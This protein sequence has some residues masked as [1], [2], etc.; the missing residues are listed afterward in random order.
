MLTWMDGTGYGEGGGRCWCWWTWWWLAGVICWCILTCLR[1]CTLR[2]SSTAKGCD[3]PQHLKEVFEAGSAT[4]IVFRFSRRFICLN[5]DSVA[6]LLKRAMSTWTSVGSHFEG[7]FSPLTR[8][9]QLSRNGCS[10]FLAGWVQQR[11]GASPGD[12]QFP[13]RMERYPQG[14]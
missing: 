10:P 8:C 3:E 6:S 4:S 14:P 1:N 7:A 12:N 11:H 5:S 13:T 9:Q 2:C